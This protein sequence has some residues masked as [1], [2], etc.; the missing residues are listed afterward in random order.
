MNQL[1]FVTGG[2]PFFSFVSPLGI[3]NLIHPNVEPYWPAGVAPHAGLLVTSEEEASRLTHN[4]DFAYHPLLHVEATS[5]S[6]DANC[7]YT[8]AHFHAA[9]HAHQLT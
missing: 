9:P 2:E 7:H 4:Q 8:S 6:V 3:I 1:P 5:S